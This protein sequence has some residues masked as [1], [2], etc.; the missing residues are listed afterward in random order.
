MTFK[1]EHRQG[2]LFMMPGS[3]LDAATIAA[4]RTHMN[5]AFASAPPKIALDFSGI[6]ELGKTAVKFLVN[7]GAQVK[8]RGGEAALF[9][10]QPQVAEALKQARM[11]DYYLLFDTEEDLNRTLAPVS[12][13][14]FTLRCL[15]CGMAEIPFSQY[16]GGTVT[17]IWDDYYAM[18]PSFRVPSL[19]RPFATTTAAASMRDQ[20]LS[21][22]A[23]HTTSDAAGNRFAETK[24]SASR[25]NSHPQTERVASQASP[26]APPAR[27]ARSSTEA[28]A[29]SSR[30]SAA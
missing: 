19:A 10:V 29:S 7:N 2:R 1:A 20:P 15:I 28:A 3:Q 14:S 13:P 22:R 23:R 27:P 6:A 12:G 21:G 8:D 30:P 9:N 26:A 18:V 24:V 25:A 11:Q 5:R 4:I 16:H 17:R